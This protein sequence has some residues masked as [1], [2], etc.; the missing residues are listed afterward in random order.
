M[1]KLP[2]IG[3]KVVSTAKETEGKVVLWERHV[4][5]P[6]GEALVSQDGKAHQ[7]AETAAVKRLIGEGVLE[8][9]NWNSK[10]DGPKNKPNANKP[11]G[12]GGRST[13]PD[14]E[15]EPDELPPAF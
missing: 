13:E 14:K 5:H 10:A 6:D 15:P 4:D 7:V 2:L 3:V 8:R 9:V 11:R 12:F 1:A